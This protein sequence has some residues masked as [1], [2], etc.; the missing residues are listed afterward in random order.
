M[1]QGIYPTKMNHLQRPITKE[2]IQFY[3]ENGF[4]CLRQIISQD[5]IQLLRESLEEAFNRDDR[6]HGARTDM[7]K[8]AN[9]L[10][11][12][13]KTIL[14]DR[15]ATTSSS[16]NNNNNN[17]EG[18]YLTE[19]ECGRWNKGVRKFEHEGPLPEICGTLIGSEQIRF[20]GD[21]CFLKEAGSKIRTAFHQDAPYFPFTG[22]DACVCWVPVDS[23]SKES[24]AMGYVKGSHVWPEYSPN[25]LVT[26]ERTHNDETPTLPNIEANES[27]YDITYFDAVS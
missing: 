2:E 22:N 23:V 24:G 18:R 27:Q 14:M 21:H 6:L 13:G 25:A 12:E 11:K 4:V 26:N 7:T 3:R 1:S 10:E 17:D 19:I 20:W 8:A 16:S 15:A 5:A 9:A